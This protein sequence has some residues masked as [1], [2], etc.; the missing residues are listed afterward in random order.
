MAEPCHL[1]DLMNLDIASNGVTSLFLIA[2][3]CGVQPAHAAL[4]HWAGSWLWLVPVSA[5]TRRAQNASCAFVHPWA[6]SREEQRNSV[7]CWFIL[8]TFPSVCHHS[9]PAIAR[10]G[11]P[12]CL[13]PRN[14]RDCQAPETTGRVMTLSPASGDQLSPCSHAPSWG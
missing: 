12:K 1:A 13:S 4:C 9:S 6:Y 11:I 5:R 3:G 8:K 10:D 7:V 2:C 14:H